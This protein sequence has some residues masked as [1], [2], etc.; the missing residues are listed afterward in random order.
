MW[1]GREE[2]ARPVS[3]CL[4]LGGHDRSP[5]P[6]ALD[7]QAASILPEAGNLC[8]V[9]PQV[10]AAR[11]SSTDAVGRDGVLDPRHVLE[12][13]RLAEE[14]QGREERPAPARPRSTGWRS[15]WLGRGCPTPPTQG[16]RRGRDR[17]TDGSAPRWPLAAGLGGRPPRLDSNA[18]SRARRPF[19]RYA[20]PRQIRS[21]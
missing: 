20:R 19:P 1:R 8:A 21:R 7:D 6:D 15:R 3:D 13:Q 17:R 2:S 5:G 10:L 4:G 18:R 14:R 12:S 9:E 11:T 16:T